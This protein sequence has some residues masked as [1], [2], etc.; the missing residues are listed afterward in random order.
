L[1]IFG[2]IISGKISGFI[3]DILIT[4]YHG[5][6]T[7]TDSYFL[8]SSISSFVYM[9]IFSSI[10]VLVVPLYSKMKNDDIISLSHRLSSLFIF[11][12]FV[13][14][15][16]GFFT[17]VFSVELVE[18]F[19]RSV[20]D[21]V[22][23]L[24]SYYLSIMSVTFIFSTI[25]SF[26]NSI[27]TVNGSVYPSYSVPLVNNIFFCFGLIFFYTSG[28]F[29]YVLM[30]GIISWIILSFIN[31]LLSK[32]WFTLNIER[33]NRLFVDR[34]ILI[35]FFPAVVSF[36]VEYAN[37]FV[38]VYF[39]TNLG[40]GA[41][42]ILGYSTKL[43]MIILSVFLVVLTT[44]IFPK[45]ASAANLIDGSVL[46][47]YVSRCLRLIV[48]FGMPIVIFM[49]FHAHDIVSLVFQRGEFDQDN[50]YQVASLFSLFVFAIPFSLA[51]DTL[52]R[53]YFSFNNTSVPLFLTSI[54]LA[55]N[56]TICSLYHNKFGII[57][58]A[59]AIII[60]VILNSFLIFIFVQLKLNNSI[61]FPFIRSIFLSTIS[62]FISYIIMDIYNS[63]IKAHWIFSSIPFFSFYFLTLFIFRIEESRLLISK[64]LR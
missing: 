48:I 55:V 33:L 4:Y 57:L 36:F 52:N 22:K 29:Q 8:S 19:S 7:V 39:S 27:Q 43:N 13:S 54:S 9:S 40:F 58:I 53:V 5:V 23:E 49:S 3:K 16:I 47:S 1:F 26:Y 31:F 34:E 35:L 25:V 62:V 12:L 24:S 51:R 37:S 6:S 14:L 41:I 56:F 2:L 15:S 42:S 10:P 32:K 44:S 59:Y 20:N 63:A 64:F 17:F 61:L 28:E 60:S 45:I 38:G 50:T 46:S 21:D 30:I 11:F 18:I